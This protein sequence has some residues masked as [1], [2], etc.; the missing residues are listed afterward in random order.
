MLCVYQSAGNDLEG[1]M[2][3]SLGLLSKLQYLN[4]A[5]NTLTS[6]VPLSIW[7]LQNLGHLILVCF[8]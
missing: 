1:P 2:P 4:L 3:D 7:Q 8:S 5:H 6:S